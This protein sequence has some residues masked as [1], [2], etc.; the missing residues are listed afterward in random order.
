MIGPVIGALLYNSLG[1]F[2]TFLILGII[3]FINLMITYFFCPDYFDKS[4]QETETIANPESVVKEVNFKTFLVNKRSNF[5]FI[6]CVF[7]CIS[8]SY[9]TAFLTDVLRHEKQI[10]PYYNGFV[11]SF[12]MLTY[13]IS[14]I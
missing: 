14:T 4:I 10:D 13:S 9:N 5:A 3:L 2:A 7:V 1:Y 12:G 8:M 11:L 6:S